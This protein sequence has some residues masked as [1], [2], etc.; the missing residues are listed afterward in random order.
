MPKLQHVEWLLTC[1]QV[2]QLDEEE[3]E[4]SFVLDRDL[5]EPDARGEVH[6]EA[7]LTSLPADL[8]E[9]ITTFLKSVRKVSPESIPDKRK[10]DEIAL[11]VMHRVFELRLA[12]YPTSES[13][14]LALLR[15]NRVSGREQMAV[16][17]RMGEKR[18]LA[19]AIS[20]AAAKIN[21]INGGA[22]GDGE[23]SG[24]STKR[25]RRA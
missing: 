13:E 16:V 3:T 23:A 20:L 6:G 22:D 9:Q 4:D 17:V 21:E 5:D 18:L 8:E 1:P 14:D 12:E 7:A 11:A 10:R 15:E 24:P 2:N 19:E 25:Q